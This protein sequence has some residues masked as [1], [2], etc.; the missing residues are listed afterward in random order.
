MKNISKANSEKFR[1]KMENVEHVGINGIKDPTCHIKTVNQP[2]YLEN[3]PQSV[4]WYNLVY[5]RNLDLWTNYAS[6]L[7]ST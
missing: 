2:Q 5:F 4:T 1:Q 3:E 7:F 6:C